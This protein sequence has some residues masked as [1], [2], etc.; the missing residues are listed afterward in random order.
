MSYR[1]VL[2]DKKEV[3]H[4]TYSFSFSKPE[5]LTYKPGQSMRIWF[6]DDEESRTFS[7]A[8]APNEKD[9]LFAMR[10]RD[11]KFKKRLASLSIGDEI[12]A[13]G[14]FGERFVLHGDASKGAVFIAGGIGI[15]PLL[16]MLSYVTKERLS[17][18]IVLFYSNRQKVDIAFLPELKRL[19]KENPNFKLVLTLTK[20]FSKNNSWDG[21]RGYINKEMLQKYISDLTKPFFYIAGPPMMVV[22]MKDTLEKAGVPSEHIN[23]KKFS[24]YE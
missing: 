1:L 8:N 23:T 20:D 3:A 17:Y 19:E 22:G 24:G 4:N 12:E 15:T 16:S 11:S 13:D 9:L 2:K 18:K 6:H 5:E 7:I 10:I 21:E 14:P